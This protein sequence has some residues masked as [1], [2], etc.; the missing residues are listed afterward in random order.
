MSSVQLLFATFRNAKW[1]IFRFD[2][3]VL[4]KMKIDFKKF[5]CFR[6]FFSILKSIFFTKK[7]KKRN[8]Q[9]CGRHNYSAPN[10]LL[11]FLNESS[12][13]DFNNNFVLFRRTN[14]VVYYHN[15]KLDLFCKQ[16]SCPVFLFTNVK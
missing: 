9:F 11:C 15:M 10:S 6:F 8:S 2:R 5:D 1:F 4:L 14:R 13:H 7:C 12:C 16:S 3:T